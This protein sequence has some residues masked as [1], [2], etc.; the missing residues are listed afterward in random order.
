[1][2]LF[3]AALGVHFSGIDQPHAQFDVLAQGRDFP[4]VGRAIF[5]HAPSALANDQDSDARQFAGPPESLKVF[6]GLRVAA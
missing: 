5:A 3:G 4:L 2:A 6:Y 1:M